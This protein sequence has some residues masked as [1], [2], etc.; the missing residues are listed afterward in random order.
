MLVQVQDN[1]ATPS[2]PSST[3]YYTS[4]RSAL[5]PLQ[6]HTLLPLQVHTDNTSAHLHCC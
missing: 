4:T 3:E 2:I 1:K 6:V 5:L